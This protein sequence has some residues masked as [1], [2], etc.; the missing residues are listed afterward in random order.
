LI[1]RVRLSRD[2]EKDLLN[3]S[4]CIS[5]HASTIVA[6]SYSHRILQYLKGFERFPELGTLGSDILPRRRIV[7]FER[8]VVTI[9]IVEEPEVVILGR[10]TATHHW[11]CRSPAAD[12]G[13]KQA[14]GLSTITEEVAFA[15]L[16]PL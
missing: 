13:K 6:R 9:F 8:R 14:E 10:L 3:I 7:G 12:K 15:T 4:D 11:S 1:Y 16:M 2:A 5:A